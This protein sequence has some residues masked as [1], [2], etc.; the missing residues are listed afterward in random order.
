MKT[1]KIILANFVEQGQP[2]HVVAF[3][4]FAEFIEYRASL[5]SS[6]FKQVVFS[7]IDLYEFEEE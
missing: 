4:S 5:S 6:S 3:S 7:E 2:P 1:K